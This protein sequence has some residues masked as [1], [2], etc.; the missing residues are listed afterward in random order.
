MKK[1]NKMEMCENCGKNEVNKDE[2][3]VCE[4]CVAKVLKQKK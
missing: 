3:N 4:E 2:R 1:D